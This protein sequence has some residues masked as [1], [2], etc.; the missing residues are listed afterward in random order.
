[1]RGKLEQWGGNSSGVNVAN[2]D[3]LGNVHP[4]TMWWHHDL[5]SVKDR[6]FSE[7]WMDTSDPVMAGLKQQPRIICCR[8]GSFAHFAICN[9]NTRV[10]ALQITNDPWAEDPACYLTD[11]E[12]GIVSTT[13]RVE[14]TPY[15]SKRHAVA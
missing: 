15:R 12:I 13:E 3:N 6:P 7:I 4:D 11:E 14:N 2:I 8:C 9:G 5:G 10:R 1:M